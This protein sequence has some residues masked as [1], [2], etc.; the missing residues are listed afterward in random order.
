MEGRNMT[1]RVWL[2]S[3]TP[4]L[5]AASFAA[6]AAPPTTYRLTHICT[7]DPTIF[8]VGCSVFGINN[9]GELVG[10]RPLNGVPQVAFIWRE[11]EFIDLNALLMNTNFAFAVAINDR[12]EVV[13]QFD[14]VQFGRRA[15]L[16]RRG[17]ITLI[18]VAPG[19]PAFAGVDINDRRE[20]LLRAFDPQG[21][22][23]AFVWRQR[24]G[25]L[26]PLELLPG[27][28]SFTDTS[29]INNR[30]A[31]VGNG[32]ADNPVGVVPLLW[33]HGTLMQVQ[34]PQGAV[35]GNASD[36]NDRGV[37]VGVA[38]FQDHGAGYRWE[39]GLATELPSTPSL[40]NDSASAINNRGA[41]AGTGVDVDEQRFVATLWP[42]RG[43]PVDLNARIADDDALKPF[44]HVHTAELINDRGHIVVRG[45]DSRNHPS[46]VSTYLLIPQH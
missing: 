39:D 34:L 18:E 11:G 31:V 37:I 29:R 6:I 32:P 19:R 3:I 42:R 1:R 16:W 20:V 13:G 4:L 7:N 44:V 41:I 23:E 22:G 30:G 46:A 14:D 15:F 5:L 35:G 12:S 25:R 43:N 40:V 33:E 27:L 36:I 28:E 45:Q 24:D 21:V 10:S 9:R 8:T 17:E 38:A 2:S 26:T